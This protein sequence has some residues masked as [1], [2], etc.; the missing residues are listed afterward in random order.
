METTTR[1]ALTE[2][3]YDQ[4]RSDMVRLIPSLRAFARGL[5]RNPDLADDLTQEAMMR[6]WASRQTFTPGTNFRAWMFRI[7]RNHYYGA[8]RKLRRETSL[9]PE[10]AERTLVQAATQEQSLHLDDVDAAMAKLPAHQ[11]EV[12]WLIAGAGMSYDDAADIV[13]V[14][15]G[16]IK[17]RLNRAR[18]G[19]KAII[20]G[21]PEVVAV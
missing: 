18:I 1:D 4:F 16:T 7:L 15:I 3:D 14:G 10:M 21:D 11:A 6:A 2:D 20:D 17:S 19:I 5:C 13:G 9:D 8:S 12:L